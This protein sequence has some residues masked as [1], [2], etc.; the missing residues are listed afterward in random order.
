[1][2]VYRR[3]DVQAM[4]KAARLFEG[5]HDFKAFSTQEI[6][7]TV[8]TVLLCELIQEKRNLDLHIVADGFLRNMVRA[9]VGTLLKVGD[10]RL[11]SSDIPKL[12]ASKER[13]QVGKNVAPHGLYFVEAG[14]EPWQGQ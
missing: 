12:L 5:K 4:Q 11:E 10:G 14:Y 13:G 2:P 6:R 1:M 3:V 8:R 9:V 7:S